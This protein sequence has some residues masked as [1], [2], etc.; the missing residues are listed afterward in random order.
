M[1]QGRA[2]KIT[3]ARTTAPEIP[4]AGRATRAGLIAGPAD[5]IVG[6]E[7]PIAGREVPVAGLVAMTTAAI[8][9]GTPHRPHRRT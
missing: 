8:T 1:A 3:E 2:A 6:R 7:V 5:Q 4:A 9:G